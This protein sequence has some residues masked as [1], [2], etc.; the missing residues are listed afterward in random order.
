[1]S[2]IEFLLGGQKELILQGVWVGNHSELANQ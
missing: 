2:N 1:M